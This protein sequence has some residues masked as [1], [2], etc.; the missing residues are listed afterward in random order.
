MKQLLQKLFKMFWPMSKSDQ[1]E[2]FRI[3]QMDQPEFYRELEGRARD[4]GLLQKDIDG[5]VAWCADDESVLLLFYRICDPRKLDDVRHVYDLI[6]QTNCY[7]AYAFVNQLPDGDGTWDIFQLSRLS[8]MA[9]CNR[10]SGP[11]SWVEEDVEASVEE[12]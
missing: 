3:L 10:V 4:L 11:G 7:V 2:W 6:A 9:H 8:Y 5:A 1:S 12:S